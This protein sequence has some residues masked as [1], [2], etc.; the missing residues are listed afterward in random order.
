MKPM[1]K[2]FKKATIATALV[3]TLGMTL[4]ACSS[5][6]P[7]AGSSSGGK[8][9][10]TIGVMINDTTNPFL[11]SLAK[12]EQAEGAKLGVTV[13]VLNGGLNNQKEISE[14][15]D[16]IAKHVDA[17]LL[18]P[19]DPT[20]ILP[21]IAAANA[22]KIP[23]VTV[24]TTAD[25][26]AKIISHIGD[27][28]YDY[29]VGLGQLTVKATGGKGNVEMLLGVLGDSPE[30]E[31]LAGFKSVLAKNPGLNLVGTEVDNWV[32]ATN[33]ADTQDLLTKYPKGQLAAIV[34]QGPQMY[35]GAAYAAKQGRSDVKLIAGDYS[36]EVKAAIQ[37]GTL[38][39]TVNQDPATEGKLGVDQAYYYLT[40]AKDK[41]KA[42][43][44]IPLPLVTKDN[45]D[46]Y[47]ASWDS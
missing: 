23:V 9:T 47:I 41:V 34:A 42:N 5:G 16:L 29:G 7:S 31:R 25:K 11:A 45:V 36:K 35:V 32:N 21:A 46:K 12:A 14:V 37:A 8:K 38:Y 13:D 20:A 40:G 19:S 2:R 30:T 4:A 17:L 33:L 26:S 28:D 3:A 44:N 24:N 43:V 15:N 22:A 1:P 39:G 27:S 10:F 18:T 6:T